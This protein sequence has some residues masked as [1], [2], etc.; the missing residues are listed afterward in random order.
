[1]ITPI[2]LVAEGSCA[3]PEPARRAWPTCNRR[4]L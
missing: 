4:H 2:A 1:M 3:A